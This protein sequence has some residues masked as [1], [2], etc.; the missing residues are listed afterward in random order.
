MAT[1]FHKED[2]EVEIHEYEV[3][4]GPES[5][6]REEEIL[7]ERERELEEDFRRSRPKNKYGW[8]F[9]S[10]QCSSGW[11]LRPQPEIRWDF[12]RPWRGLFV[13]C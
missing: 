2:Q 3:L 9:S 13:F 5:V 4:D 7:R 12:S 8:A 6:I 10:A 1:Q 11:A